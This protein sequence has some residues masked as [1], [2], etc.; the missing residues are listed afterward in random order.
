MDSVWAPI[1]FPYAAAGFHHGL[2][3]DVSKR[4]VRPSA[5]DRAGVATHCWFQDGKPQV[6]AAAF[7]SHNKI[8]QFDGPFFF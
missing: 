3:G 1:V 6:T 4:N 8:S 2:T 7:F 5:E